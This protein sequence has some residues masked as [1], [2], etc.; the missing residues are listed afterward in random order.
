MCLHVGD[1]IRV[2]MKRPAANLTDERFAVRMS[3][4]VRFQTTFRMEA[5]W[6]LGAGK[7]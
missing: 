2:L 3:H 5:G 4:T 7:F 1:Q 6:T